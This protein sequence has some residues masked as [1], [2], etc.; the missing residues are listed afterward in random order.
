MN[1]QETTTI[2]K[3]SLSVI[4]LPFA[5]AALFVGLSISEFTNHRQYTPE[6]VKVADEAAYGD[7]EGIMR[8]FFDARRDPVTHKLDY[9]AMLAA[10]DLDQ[11]MSKAKRTH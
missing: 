3:N 9:Q 2:R 10:A 1:L 11:A 8:F 5:V 7:A 6:K 4:G